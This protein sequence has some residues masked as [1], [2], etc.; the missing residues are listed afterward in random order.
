MNSSL[1]VTLAKWTEWGVGFGAP[2]PHS[3][4]WLAV[5]VA[6]GALLWPVSSGGQEEAAG[7]QTAAV[8]FLWL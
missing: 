2:K 5:L 4:F 6:V 1:S 3:R 8:S 7:Y